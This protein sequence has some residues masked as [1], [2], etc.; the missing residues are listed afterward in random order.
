MSN[1]NSVHSVRPTD[2]DEL[3][4]RAKAFIRIEAS[5]LTALADY[6]TEEL[7]DATEA[8]LSARGKV[9]ISGVGKSQLVGEKISA[10]LASTGT[11]SHTLDPTDAMHGDLGRIHSDD[12]LLAMSNSGETME[13]S[14]V[15]SSAKRIPVK[16]IAM[17]GNRDSTLAKLSDIVL[18]IGR[19]KEACPLGLAPTTSTTAMMALGDALALVLLEQRGFTR[20]DF[21]RLHPAGALGKKLSRRKSAPDASGDLQRLIPPGTC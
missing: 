8:I 11:P 15:V 14:H 5:A 13:L 16:V 3:L 17:T 2:T 12:I 1:V 7:C 6:L 21:A 20:E 4:E 10:T 18:D 19:A 9:V